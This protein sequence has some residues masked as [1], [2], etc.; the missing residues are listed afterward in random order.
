MISQFWP[1]QLKIEPSLP[2]MGKTAEG[3]GTIGKSISYM[4]SEMLSDIQV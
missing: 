2:K 3:T 1:K 4:L